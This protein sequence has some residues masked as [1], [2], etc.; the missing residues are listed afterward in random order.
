MGYIVDL[1]NIHVWFEFGQSRI[2]DLGTG[3]G[4]TKMS[5][6]IETYTITHTLKNH[7]F[8]FRGP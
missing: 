6:D 3:Y 7:F 4:N 8:G 1:T 2:N 5:T